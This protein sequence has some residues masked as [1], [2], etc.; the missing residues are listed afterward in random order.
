MGPGSKSSGLMLV[1]TVQRNDDRRGHV[2]FV[3]GIGCVIESYGRD[4]VLTVLVQP[5]RGPKQ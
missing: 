3:I 1:G 4:G 5:L 2:V